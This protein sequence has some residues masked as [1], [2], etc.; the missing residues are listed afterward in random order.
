MATKRLKDYWFVVTKT[1]SAVGTRFLTNDVPTQSTMEDLVESCVTKWT[2]DVEDNPTKHDFATKAQALTGTEAGRVITPKSLN[3]YVENN[4]DNGGTFVPNNS[5]LAKTD[6]FSVF[7]NK[8]VTLV[9]TIPTVTYT[10][11]SISGGTYKADGIGTSYSDTLGNLEVFKELY[12]KKSTYKCKLNFNNLANTTIDQSVL[13]V[14]VPTV[15][16]LKTGTFLHPA[17]SLKALVS[18]PSTGTANAS[19]IGYVYLTESGG[20][21]TKIEV[22]VPKGVYTNIK[23]GSNQTHCYFE[24]SYLEE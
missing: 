9:K 16:T 10:S 1:I 19:G 24:F 13:V 3:A 2:T 4:Y 5:A 18:S 22:S 8:L 17:S 11:Y 20:Y 23:A 7:F 12:G 15:S 14:Y 6:V 21:L